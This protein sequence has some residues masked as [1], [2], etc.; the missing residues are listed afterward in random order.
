MEEHVGREAVAML[1]ESG[2]CAIEANLRQSHV[3]SAD[4]THVLISGQDD[5]NL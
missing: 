3:F 4:E 5:R 1:W 2:G